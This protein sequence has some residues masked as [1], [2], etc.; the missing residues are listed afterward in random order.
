MPLT[1][2]TPL[3]TAVVEARPVWLRS[4]Q[5][6]LSEFPV[7][8]TAAQLRAVAAVPIVDRGTVAG[9][10]GWKFTEEQPFDDGQQAFLLSIAADCLPLPKTI[11]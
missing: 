7:F 6:L 4:R 5:E 11:G 10:I 9:S 1:M 3:C 8:D 2:R